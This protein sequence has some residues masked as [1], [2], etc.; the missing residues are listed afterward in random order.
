M[1]VSH[2]VNKIVRLIYEY[3]W[4]LDEQSPDE[5]RRYM[6]GQIDKLEIMFENFDIFC[7]E[8]Y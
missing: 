1:G 8:K 5:I 4:W 3:G 7:D 6:E 2:S